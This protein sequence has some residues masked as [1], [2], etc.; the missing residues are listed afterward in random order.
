[1]NCVSREHRSGLGSQGVVV[2][3]GCSRL[4]PMGLAGHLLLAERGGAVQ[5]LQGFEAVLHH[6]QAT[7]EEDGNRG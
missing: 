5:L 1:M 4:Q 7:S 3:K 2:A 6:C